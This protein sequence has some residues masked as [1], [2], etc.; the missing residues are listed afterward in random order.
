MQER[1]YY[2]PAELVGLIHMSPEWV[3][4]KLGDGTLPGHKVGG[5]W[6]IPKAKME[7]WMKEHE[8][9]V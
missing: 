2:T 9:F 1:N 8:E 6:I 4:M 7:R 3:H 5:R